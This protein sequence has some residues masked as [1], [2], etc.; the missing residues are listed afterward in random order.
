MNFKIKHS[1]I[2]YLFFIGIVSLPII[3]FSQKMGKYAT[4]SI[5]CGRDSRIGPTSAPS[6]DFSSMS[7]YTTPNFYGILTINKNTGAIRVTDAR[8]AGNYQI[9]VEGIKGKNSYKTTFTLKVKNPP[10]SPGNFTIK[11]KS[12]GKSNRSVAVGDFNNDKIQDF[13][14]ANSYTDSV[15]VYLGDSLAGKFK[16]PRSFKVGSSPWN[17][18]VGDFNL[19]GK[20]DIATANNGSN[21]VSICLGDGQ[22]K[23]TEKTKL[24]LSSMP[25]ALGVGDFNK[26]GIQDLAILNSVVSIRL[27][28]GSGTFSG[29]TDLNVGNNPQSI[30]IADFNKDSIADLATGNINSN[31]VSVCIGKGDGKFDAAKNYEVGNWNRSF[32]EINVSP[33]AIATGDFDNDG[34]QD[35]VTSNFG[36]STISIRYGNGSGGF[37]KRFEND[38]MVQSGP[39]GLALGDFNGDGKSDIVTGNYD[40]KIIFILWSTGSLGTVNVNSRIWSIASGNFQNAKGYMDLI[41]VDANSGTINLILGK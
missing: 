19:D 27:G 3:S 10:V 29:N 1:L 24:S 20:Q 39:M 12:K 28:D 18:V 4:S 22:G 11:T 41:G 33:G 17:V 30:A 2:S 23:F 35:F 34:N 7:V 8:P 38:I 40:Q 6:K 13:V 25:F 32:P 16:T 5:V 21:N 15:T 9:T 36:D 26:D 31:N 14:I 37:E